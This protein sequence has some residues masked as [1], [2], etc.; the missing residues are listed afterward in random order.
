[1]SAWSKDPICAREGCGRKKSKSRVNLKYCYTC[2]QGL[3]KER[4]LDAHDKRVTE[5]KGIT[6]A[7]YWAIYKAQGGRC[8]LC[9]LAQGIRKRLAVD[10]DHRCKEGHDPKY[11]CRKCVRGLLCVNC[12]RN[13]LGRAAHD[14]PEFF[15]RGYDYLLTPPARLILLRGTF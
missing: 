5:T 2:E 8:A 15:T 6:G 13:V 10:H 14:D 7:E 11:A 12:N 3:K 9:R 4:A 1:M